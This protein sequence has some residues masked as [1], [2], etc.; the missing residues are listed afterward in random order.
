MNKMA[1][2]VK[3]TNHETPPLLYPEKFWKLVKT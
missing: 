1:L 3:P 2:D